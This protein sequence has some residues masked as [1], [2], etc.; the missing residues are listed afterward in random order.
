MAQNRR[1]SNFQQHFSSKTTNKDAEAL[2]FQQNLT[3]NVNFLN[4]TDNHVQLG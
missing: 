2:S 1:L 4:K 3:E